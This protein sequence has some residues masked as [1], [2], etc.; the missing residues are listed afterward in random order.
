MLGYSMLIYTQS[1]K[2][3]LYNKIMSEHVGYL[4]IMQKLKDITF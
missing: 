4:S 2:F 1:L 3:N